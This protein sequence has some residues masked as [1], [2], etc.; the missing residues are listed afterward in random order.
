MP[1]HF[2]LNFLLVSSVLINGIF[3]KGEKKDCSVSLG[4]YK[5]SWTADDKNVNFELIYSDFPNGNAWTGV[6]FG[7]R[8]LSGLDAIIVKVIDGRV[9]VTDEFVQGYR[10][11]WPDQ[12][13]DVTVKS[14][15]LSNGDLHVVFSR[16]IKATEPDADHTI[17]G[18]SEWKFIYGL[19]MARGPT[20]VGKHTK[21]PQGKTICI[22]KCQ[23]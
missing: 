7:E 6:A 3:P 21:T 22:D 23:K 17:S 10:P 18:C 13:Q 11:S 2:V 19:G 20:G 4:N 5:L 9:L 15:T 14:A 1:L 8:M 12:S 16:P